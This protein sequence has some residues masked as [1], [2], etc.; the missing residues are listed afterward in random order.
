MSS[1]STDEP[2]YGPAG[3]TAAVVDLAVLAFLILSALAM[4]Y[5][6]AVFVIVPV[7][8]V[9]AV[10]AFFM[11]KG[12]GV[13]AQIGRGLLSACAAAAVTLLL[14]GAAALVGVVATYALG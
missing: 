8:A 2:R 12:T 5:Y 14:I 6:P 10:V 7:V 9:N 11:S 13:T 4:T 1:G 3:F